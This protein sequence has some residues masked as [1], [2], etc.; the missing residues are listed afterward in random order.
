ME[1]IINYIEENRSYL[2][3]S[4]IVLEQLTDD[5]FNVLKAI[6]EEMGNGE[7]VGIANT[8]VKSHENIAD[9]DNSRLT[10][11]S[12]RGSRE[13]SEV[14]NHSVVY[15]NQFQTFKGKQRRDIAVVQFD[16]FTITLA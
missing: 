16:G 11:W 2:G 6:T 8:L 12:E 13:A 9:F 3:D 1:N 4:L 7:D 5:Q 14:Q 15:Y 10:Q